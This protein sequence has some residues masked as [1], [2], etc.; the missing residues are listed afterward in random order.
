MF[1]GW[2]LFDDYAHRIINHSI[3]NLNKLA[4]FF[5]KNVRLSYGHTEIISECPT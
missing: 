2:F 5:K 1:H 4:N 3:N